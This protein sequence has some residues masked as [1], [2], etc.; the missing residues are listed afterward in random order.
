MKHVKQFQPVF[1]SHPAINKMIRSSGKSGYKPFTNPTDKEIN[2]MKNIE[3][4][5]SQQAAR[6]LAFVLQTLDER[7]IYGLIESAWNQ[8][9]GEQPE[10][11][12]CRLHENML[13]I[14]LWLH[15]EAGG[16]IEEE[17]N[18]GG[19]LVNTVFVPTFEWVKKHGP[20]PEHAAEV[21][22]SEKNGEYEWEFE[23]ALK[24]NHWR[25]EIQAKH[26][27]ISNFV[28]QVGEFFRQYGGANFVQMDV[29]D[30][31][32]RQPLTLTV[33]KRF[34]MNPAEKLRKMLTEIVEPL[35]LSEMIFLK[36]GEDE[37]CVCKYCHK[38]T[39][40]FAEAGP[41]NRHADNCFF[42]KAIEWGEREQH[43]KPDQPH[44]P[45]TTDTVCR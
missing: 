7:T 35:A 18:E 22:W 37:T 44:S 1:I 36:P 45:T 42:R 6:V 38:K 30:P 17:A 41:M 32:S 24:D 39:W 31:I 40:A 25:A 15:R 27:G 5:K 12:D 4:A 19:F 20:L 11:E 8:L 2:T 16:W 3:L 29:F 43:A 23:A 34:G 28:V 14:L 21:K 10:H 26:L 33:Q 9:R 13:A